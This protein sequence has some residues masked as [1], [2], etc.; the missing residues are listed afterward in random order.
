MV[1]SCD[2]IVKGCA[3]GADRIPEETFE[4][5]EIDFRAKKEGELDDKDK[6]CM[7]CI[8]ENGTL[9]LLDRYASCTTC[10]ELRRDVLAKQKASAKLVE[11]ELKAEAAAGQAIE[12][13]RKS[14]EVHRQSYMNP[15]NEM[16]RAAAVTA[17]GQ[18]AIANAAV[19]EANVA[20]AT[21]SREIS[22]LAK[23]DPNDIQLD[24]KTEAELFANKHKYHIAGVV[25]AVA[26][27]S[28]YWMNK[29]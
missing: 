4:Q 17:H 10:G 12:A 18:A 28:I 15:A 19:S 7:K 20:K 16:I 14:V 27:V 1:S 8:T 2:H 23:M 3:A 11:A 13:Q 5:A 26:V 24:W 29:S 6:I 25:A 9:G 22:A 21:A